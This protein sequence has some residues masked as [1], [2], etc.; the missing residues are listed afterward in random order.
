MKQTPSCI[1]V[2]DDPEFARSVQSWLNRLYP[3][4][5]VIVFLHSREA[6]HHVVSRPVKCLITNFRMPWLDGL[7]LARRARLLCAD[8]TPIV[9]MS[10]ENIET[11]A[12]AQGA[13]L[14]VRKPDI[15]ELLKGFLDQ[16][17]AG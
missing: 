14:F 1:V 3:A 17:C 16:R 4:L 13:D 6:L 5:E 9:V 15:F 11:E 7:G 8:D 12:L 2:D 10:T